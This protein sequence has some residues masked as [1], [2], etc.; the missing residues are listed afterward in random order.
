[1]ADQNE[2][3]CQLGGHYQLLEF[4]SILINGA[5]LWA[6]IGT[7]MAG[8]RIGQHPRRFGD[9]RCHFA[10]SAQVGTEARFKDHGIAAGT[11]ASYLDMIWLGA[12]GDVFRRSEGY[13]R[14]WSLCRRLR[15]G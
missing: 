15:M 9:F 2:R 13:G 12:N 6:W 11:R 8:A 1:M 3:R 5:R 14:R 10:P 4:F 7:A